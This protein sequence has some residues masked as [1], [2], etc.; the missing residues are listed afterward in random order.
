MGL[1]FATIGIICADLSVVALDWWF[2]SPVT[3]SLSYQSYIAASSL[4]ALTLGAVVTQRWRENV[5]NLE[6]ARIDRVTGLP[7]PRALDEWLA[8]ND[9]RQ[10]LTVLLVAIDNMRWVHE[11]LHRQGI[12][13][14]VC[15]VGY[16]LQQ[17]PIG[18]RYLAHTSDAEFAVVL[19]GSD[20]AMAA[21]TA[22][23]I[24]HAFERPVD[25]GETE[26]Y[27]TVSVGISTCDDRNESV[28]LLVPHAE[29][30]LDEARARGVESVVFHV[31]REDEEPLISLAAQLHRAVQ[32]DEFELVYQP[33]FE[34][35]PHP[36][37][38]YAFF[39]ARISGVEALLR[40]NHP[41]RGLSR[42]RT[43]SLTCWSR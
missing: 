37:E 19:T 15:G 17:L 25:I 13:A 34:L 32:N 20:R 9:L 28:H 27:A 41:T 8:S 36:D 2:R 16:R 1:R 18:E 26:I 21:L 5:A 38:D 22:E 40:W 7:N 11:G 24:R 42:R 33:I 31:P 30:A 6:R 4:T 35:P 10:P 43:R 14:F 29:Q 23:K 3:Q 12:D 39:G